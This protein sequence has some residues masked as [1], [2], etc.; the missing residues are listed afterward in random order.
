MELNNELCIARTKLIRVEIQKIIDSLDRGD[1]SFSDG[2]GTAIMWLKSARHWLGEHLAVV[3]AVY[4]YPNGNNPE[5][6]IVDPKTDVPET[7]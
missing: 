1:V 3:G 4:P 2:V 7:A 6:T 5:N